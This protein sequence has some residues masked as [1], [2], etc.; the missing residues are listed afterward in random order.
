MQAKKHRT[1]I[2][3]DLGAKYTGVVI[4]NYTPGEELTQEDLT[5]FTVVMPDS[6]KMT[7]SQAQRT[8]V[9]HR[10]RGKKRFNLARR[11]A[12][13]LINEK[14]AASNISLSLEEQKKMTEAVSGLL[15]RRGY[16]RIESEINL[17]ILEETN[18][19]W[20]SHHEVMK[21]YFPDSN[22]PL[23]DQW[24]DLTNKTD[25]IRNLD[26]DISK[27]SVADFK[28]AFKK[29][30]LEKD[31]V[32]VAKDAACAVRDAAHNI[33]T[34]QVMGHKHRVKYLADLMK[35]LT[36]GDSRLKKV[37]EA[38]GGVERFHHL[39][40]NISNLQLRAERW[41]FNAP[42]MIKGDEWEPGKLKQSIIRAF[43]YFH[44]S[45]E[46]DEKERLATLVSELERSQDIIETLCSINPERTIPPYEDQNNRRPPLDQTLFLDPRKLTNHFQDKWTIWAKAFAKTEPELEEALEHNLEQTDRKS[47]IRRDGNEPLPKLQYQFAYILQRVLDRSRP[48]D[49]YAI[50]AQADGIVLKNARNQLESVLGQQHIDTFLSF[51]SDY[52]AEVRSA[53]VGLWL[54]QTSLFLERADIHPPVKKKILCLLVGSVLQNQKLGKQFLDEVWKKKVGRSSVRSI[55]SSVE[56]IRKK[57]GG[58]FNRLYRGALL[59]WERKEKLSAEEKGFVALSQKVEDASTVIADTL[60][61]SDSQKKRFSNPYSLAQLFTIIETERDGF[62]TVSVA[63][64]NENN[65]RMQMREF[66]DE[67]GNKRE[68]ANCARLPA[69]ATRPF[70]GV[71]RR[72]IDRKAWEIAQRV[73][74]SIRSS[75]SDNQC[76]V[77]IPLFVEENRFEFSA[78]VAELKCN[79]NARKKLQSN[80]E[81]QYKRWQDKTERIKKASHSI[82][83][84]TGKVIGLKGEIDH[85]IPRSASKKRAGTIFN[86]EANLIYTSQEGNQRKGNQ[87]YGL[88]D[89]ADNYLKEV[90]HS[91]SLE[92]I[93]QRIEKT[94]LDLQQTKRLRFF[95]LLSDDEQACVRHALFLPSSSQARQIVVE[96]LANQSRARVNGTQMWLVRQLIEKLDK[97]LASWCATTGN[98][99]SFCAFPVSPEVSMRLRGNLGEYNPPMKKMDVQPVASHS[100]DALCALAVGSDEEYVVDPSLSGI[101][102][103]RKLAE[104][105]P[106]ECEIVQI[107]RKPLE[108]K[109]TF[110]GVPLFKDGIYSERYLPIFTH[111]GKVYVGFASKPDDAGAMPG[112]LKVG[113]K[114]PELLLQL[115]SPYFQ[116]PYDGDIE[117]NTTYTLNRSKVLGL[118]FDVAHKKTTDENLQ[119]ASLIEALSFCTKRAAVSSVLW[120]AKEKK[121]I[122]EERFSEGKEWQLKVKISG[123]RQVQ[124]EGKL[125]LPVKKEW[126]KIYSALTATTSEEDLQTVIN[127][128]WKRPHKQKLS[129]IPTHRE[130]SLP[131]LDSPSG[132]FRIRRRT[133]A[134]QDIV[135]VHAANAKLA[136]FAQSNGIT[137]W[138]KEV[139]FERF[140]SLKMTAFSAR[141]F[142]E[143]ETTSLHEWR[144]VLDG[145]IK[146][147]L[148]PGSAIRFNVRI[149]APFEDVRRWIMAGEPSMD[150]SSFLEIPALLKLKS[151]KDVK[152]K[153]FFSAFPPELK[154]I[155]AYPRDTIVFEN[156]GERVRFRY[157]VISN[158]PS[159]LKAYDN[160]TNP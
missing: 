35:D 76:Q 137:L 111:G 85:I 160:S 91:D 148:E 29:M 48:L 58:D 99:I 157:T 78:S 140:Q 138:K 49:P 19:E 71:V 74:E 27:F 50:R 11:L 142:P 63:A 109:T 69:D 153:A 123:L 32:G 107:Q 70:D 9:R 115:L 89:L 81:A 139:L 130:L 108:N 8:A 114:K 131:I 110:G 126:S 54:P 101:S 67:N 2:G 159:T 41:Y 116:R 121:I 92:V 25:S 82:C 68:C 72:M 100:I 93:E 129:H 57:Y 37:I 133:R 52:Y 18:S 46:R 154:D 73:A 86:A 30:G 112:A 59:Q 80:S 117:R 96:S 95:D 75:V 44:P 77:E 47:R 87:L 158:K 12:N 147:W 145:A 21:H 143:T 97:K 98:H 3:I 88:R 24:E 64:H 155:L 141:Y 149:E 125:T 105:Y 16:S 1:A 134:Q 40:G 20:F 55:C 106:K 156:V 33:V 104:I 119:T 42:N 51:A 62:T 13:L 146:V 14:L 84:Y 38:F 150:I 17:D 7:L 45:Q 10:I 39:I 36:R 136:G 124:L 79:T 26:R 65:W 60:G 28:A 61:L 15:R 53:K 120:D 127:R 5:A 23:A 128:F 122:S 56:V 31:E 94:I 43:K 34:Q 113:G 90:F 66:L 83:P 144:Q 132:A 118:F 6:E 22:R 103:V 4:A 152:T 102:D 151:K 135:Q